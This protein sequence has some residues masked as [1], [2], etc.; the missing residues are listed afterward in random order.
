MARDTG[1]RRWEQLRAIITWDN[2][3]SLEDFFD[4]L[5]RV[6]GIVDYDIVVIHQESEEEH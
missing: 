3:H 2:H 4:M 6:P 1:K 5:S